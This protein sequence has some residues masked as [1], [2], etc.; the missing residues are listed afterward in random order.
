[1]SEW[2]PVTLRRRLQGMLATGELDL[3]FPAAGQ[4]SGRHRALYDVGRVDLSLARLVEAHTD[5]TA[6]LHE[7]DRAP[8]RRSLYGVWASEGPGEP[9]TARAS[10]RAGVVLNGAKDFCSG[11]GI[12]DAALITVHVG[13]RIRLADVSLDAK[14]VS[15]DKPAWASPA[16]RATNTTR[17][18]FRQVKVPAS[19]MVGGPGWY[20]DRVGFWHGAIG[21][22]ACWAGGAAGLVEA[23]HQRRH[24]NP[25]T[26]AQ[27]G[28]LEAARWALNAYLDQ[29]G[30]MIDRAGTNHHEARQRALTV[31]HLVE[32]TCTEVMDRFGRATGPALLAFD[33]AIA[34][35]YAELTLYIRQSHAERDLEAIVVS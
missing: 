9:L 17:V 34:R 20:L 18:R 14:G 1:M 15:I 26:A 22:A 19:S 31:R 12:V 16:F 21:P 33:A 5:A 27:L 23:A 13:D 32:R 2:T 8:G 29:S 11:A 24:R 3:P 4:T 25:H 30:Q 35:R 6:I 10:S 7:A 28:A